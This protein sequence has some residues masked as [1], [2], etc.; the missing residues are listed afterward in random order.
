MRPFSPPC[1]QSGLA[2]RLAL[3]VVAASYPGLDAAALIA[4]Y[5]IFR[6][7]TIWPFERWLAREAGAHDRPGFR[8]RRRG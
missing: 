7:V 2:C 5:L 6:R 1:D 8:G 4:A 3:A